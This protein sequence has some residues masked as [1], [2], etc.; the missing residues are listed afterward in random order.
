MFSSRRTQRLHRPNV[1]IAVYI[2]ATN[3]SEWLLTNEKANAILAEI[4]TD[5]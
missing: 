3:P 5:G 2:K 4:I 1:Y